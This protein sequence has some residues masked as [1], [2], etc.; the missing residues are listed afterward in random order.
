MLLCGLGTCGLRWE[1][2]AAWGRTPATAQHAAADSLA[3]GRYAWRRGDLA[4]A[5]TQWRKAARLYARAQ[6]PHA[7]RVA[8]LYLAQAYEALGH[9]EKAE[10]SLRTA[11]QQAE[12]AADQVQRALLLSRLGNLALS[13][14]KHDHAEQYLDEAQAA[15]RAFDNPGLSATILH[16]RG[17]LFMARRRLQDAFAAYR[18]SAAFAEQAHQ[19]GMAARS[20]AHAAV[21]AEQAQHWQAAEALLDEALGRLR[22]LPPSHDTAYEL[23]FIG[24]AYHRLATMSPPLILRAA[25]VLNEAA[26]M[27]TTL[28]DQRALSYAWGDLGRLYEAQQRYQEALEL[29]RRAVAAAQRTNVPE[30]LYQWHWQTGRLLRARGDM[31][32]AMAAYERAITIVQS[33]RETLQRG[34]Q[35]EPVSFRKA[36]GPL[37]LQYVDILLRQAAALE[38][39]EQGAASPQYERY[40]RQARTTVER[41]KRAELQDYFRDTCVDAVRPTSV[42]L[43]QVSPD[44]AVIYPILLPDRT[45]LLVSLRTGLRRVEVPVTGPQLEKRVRIFLNAL[46][47]RD[48]LRYLR[49]AQQLYT[50]LIRPLEADLVA[51]HIQ[52]LVLVPDGALRLLPFAALHDGQRFLIE[53]Y[54]LAI[55]PGLTLTDPRPLPRARVDALAVGTSEGVAGFAPLPRV[56]EELRTVQQ[57]FGGTV[58]LDQDFSPERVDQ[59][60]RRRSFGIVH[61]AAHGQFAP[62]ATDSFLITAQGKFTFTQLAAMVGR[63]RFRKQPLELLTLSACETARGD[64]RAALGLAGVAIQAGA[65]S[66]LATLWL[67]EDEAAALL[68]KSFYRHLQV[69]GTSRAQALQQAQLTLLRHP[70]YSEPFFWAPFLLI[71]N[72]L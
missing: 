55:T 5:A 3:A 16:T 47:A 2:P 31:P 42:E 70:Q 14:G 11:L 26:R 46:E 24:Q 51:L 1:I 18:E 66:A 68:M 17:N 59:S 57:L 49:H 72:W 25:T 30:A 40:L 6:Q 65:R 10:Q 67:V 34:Q 23:L 61:I 50:W 39:Q 58:L 8:L 12:K 48:P 63:L 27:A 52:T 19:L 21:A 69:P 38:Q 53:T 4:Q 41:F 13:Q 43:K 44:A 62:E 71:N 54:A 33:L 37:Y 9:Y 29:T 7:H 35:R 56:P 60:L 45:E 64:D 15:A 22:Q 32:A 20:L 36:L 28:Q